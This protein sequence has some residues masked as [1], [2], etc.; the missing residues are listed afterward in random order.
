[1]TN[2]FDQGFKQTYGVTVSVGG[3]SRFIVADGRLKKSGSWFKLAD[4]T[5]LAQG[6]IALIELLRENPDLLGVVD[7]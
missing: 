6:E 5:S 4:G 3:V 2:K 7:V 1:M